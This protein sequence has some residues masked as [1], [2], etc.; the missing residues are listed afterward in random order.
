M[1]ITAALSFEEQVF[2]ILENK[3]P[4]NITQLVNL[5]IHLL[6]MPEEQALGQVMDLMNRGKIK[7]ANQTLPSSCTFSSYLKSS[8]ARWYWIIAICALI[9]LIVVFT[10]PEDLAPWSYLRNILGTIFVV[11]LPG[12]TFIKALFPVKMPFASSEEKMV[13]VERIAFSIGFSL[14]IVPL[15]AL[16]MNYT[17]LGIGLIPIVF[18]LFLLILVFSTV[19]V[20]RDYH[21]RTKS[22][23]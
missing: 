3:K 14:A 23:S 8:R 15:V 18:S 20:V 5:V 19:A 13:S 6:K 12:Y 2:Q 17:P 9:T 22:E 4:Q 7:L 1:S 10:V 11:Y 16:V 21:A